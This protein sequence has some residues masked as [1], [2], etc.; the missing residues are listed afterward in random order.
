[1]IVYYKLKTTGIQDDL[2]R[3]GSYI[4][5]ISRINNSLIIDIMP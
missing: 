2:Q 1:M 4:N 5:N 3:H